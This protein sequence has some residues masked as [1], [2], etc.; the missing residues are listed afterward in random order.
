MNLTASGIRAASNKIQRNT[1]KPG[2]PERRRKVKGGSVKKYIVLFF[3]LVMESAA[4][5]SSDYYNKP[6]H[7]LREKSGICW[8]TMVIHKAGFKQ[9]Y[10]EISRWV[11]ENRNK[12]DFLSVAFD[13]DSGAV[14][15]TLL[16]DCR[17]LRTGPVSEY[18][19]ILTSRTDSL[20]ITFENIR[21]HSKECRAGLRNL[22]KTEVANKVSNLPDSVWWDANMGHPYRG[23]GYPEGLEVKPNLDSATDRLFAAMK[24]DSIRLA[25][26]IAHLFARDD[27]I[28]KADS[29]ARLKIEA[30]IDTVAI[31]KEIDSISAVVNVDSVTVYR[32]DLVMFKNQ[33]ILHD[34]NLSN[35]TRLDC[36]E[37]LLSH[38]A[39][40]ASAVTEYLT[41]L[42]KYC[43][44]KQSLYY[45][46]RKTI[47]EK[48]KYACTLNFKISQNDCTRVQ[49]LLD[50][51]AKK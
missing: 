37:F 33:P 49:T 40:S 16:S 7:E 3:F 26:S 46:V 14:Q 45:A 43:G 20:R 28:A 11:T 15:I 13:K 5:D 22:M 27:S 30:A 38:K 50:R 39:R 25:D 19:M 9:C 51:L 32:H 4:Q 47:A 24:A 35:E 17:A 2:G 34:K 44:D 41:S 1:K 6:V 48:D 23:L 12:Y 10:R 18:Y 8:D 42:K 31:R 21:P 36:L 29:I